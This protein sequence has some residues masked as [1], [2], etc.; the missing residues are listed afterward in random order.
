V[1]LGLDQD[2]SV[3]LGLDQ[4]PSVRLGLDQDPSVRLDLHPDP[5]VRLDLHPD[6]SVRLDR[7][8]ERHR[9]HLG[10]H[11]HPHLEKLFF[12]SFKSYLCAD[13]GILGQNLPQSEF[14]FL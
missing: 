1:R 6:P 3:R 4:D 13:L 8:Q 12:F 11:H 9:V 7:P 10:G 14:F 2:P 5:S